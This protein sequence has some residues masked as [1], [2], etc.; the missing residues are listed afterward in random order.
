MQSFMNS[1]SAVVVVMLL[2]LVGY[3]MGRLGWM[4]AEHKPFLTRLIIYV[5]MPCMCLNNIQENFTREMLSGALALVFAPALGMAM[6]LLL[7][8]WLARRLGLPRG[9]AG[10]FIAMCGFS[11]SIFIGC[12]MCLELF[13]QEAIPYVMCVYLANSIMF[14]IVG[15]GIISR[16]GD[17]DGKLFSLSG[18]KKVV[19]NPPFIAIMVATALLLLDVRLPHV[20]MSATGY[21]GNI[22]SPLALIYTGFIVYEIGFKGLRPD[23]GQLPMLGFRFLLS[24][25]LGVMLCGILGISGLGRSVCLIEMAMPVM[26]QVVVMSGVFGADE[27]YAAKGNVLSILCSF[28]VIPI[29]MMLV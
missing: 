17:G 5:G 13:G 14:Q 12:P 26:T 1:V 19:T 25:L 11:N 28:A 27:K 23:R 9:Q 15:V 2:M 3:F 8:G 18:V 24:P 10:P 29:L 6:L 4:K 21:L 7:S 22:V 20:I 16:S